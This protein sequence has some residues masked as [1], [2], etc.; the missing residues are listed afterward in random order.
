MPVLAMIIMDGTERAAAMELNEVGVVAV[1]PR[2]IDN[3]LA[4]QLGY[5]TLL[6]M[7][8]TGA[9]LMNDPA[10]ERWYEMFSDNDIRVLDSEVIFL[11]FVED[12]E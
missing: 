8:V 1:N 4:N 10:S 9:Q 5:G 3:P 12:E 11:P 2:L 7:Y 6:G